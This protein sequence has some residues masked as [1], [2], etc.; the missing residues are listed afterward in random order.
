MDVR[1]Q[2]MIACGRVRNG[3]NEMF[4]QHLVDFNVNKMVIYEEDWD[5]GDYW[6]REIERANLSHLKRLHLL[7][8]PYRILERVK[9][10]QLTHFILDDIPSFYTIN[11]LRSLLYEQNALVHINIAF[12]L[13]RLVILCDRLPSVL[14]CGNRRHHTRRKDLVDSAKVRHRNNVT[15]SSLFSI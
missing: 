13:E 6:G 3:H 12:E 15:R 5:G 11:I 2:Q 9:R 4:F 7:G 14:E 8:S 1:P 10:Y